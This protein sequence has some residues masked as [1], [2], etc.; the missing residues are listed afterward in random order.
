MEVLRDV[1]VIFTLNESL[2]LSSTVNRLWDRV[3]RT[4]LSAV[5]DFLP[6]LSSHAIALGP[7]PQEK[8]KGIFAH[9]FCFDVLD[10]QIVFYR[11]AQLFLGGLCEALWSEYYMAGQSRV[12]FEAFEPEGMIQRSKERPNRRFFRR[13]LYSS[14]LSR[15]GSGGS[16]CPIDLTVQ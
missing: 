14:H 5:F 12:N 15:L 3:R 16:Y 7:L 10:Q 6:V 1:T 13:L 2:T 9:Y 4:F 11:E 8:Y